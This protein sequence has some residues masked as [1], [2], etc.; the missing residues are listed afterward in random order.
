MDHSFFIYGYSRHSKDL[1]PTNKG[2]DFYIHLSEP[3]HL[4]GEWEC[5]LVQFQYNA[6]SESPYYVCCDIVAESYAGDFKLP[7]LRR[8]RLKN[9]QFSHV[10]YVPLKTRDFSSIH[11]YLKSWNNKTPF[12]VRGGTHCTLH[13]RRVA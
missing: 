3:V 7:I 9:T 5:G 11:F 2:Q 10:I 6:S 8:V 1:Y 4:E 13:F 12:S